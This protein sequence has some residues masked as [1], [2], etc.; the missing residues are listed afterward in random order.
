LLYNRVRDYV[1]IENIILNYGVTVY[2]IKIILDENPHRG[3]GVGK[4]YRWYSVDIIKL[5]MIV[6]ITNNVINRYKIDLSAY[7]IQ[8][9]MSFVSFSNI[10][11]AMI[12]NKC[13]VSF[14]EYR[15]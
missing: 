5:M 2:L 10:I 6:T 8:V 9:G 11:F 15:I 1:E 12:S 13:V 3:L 7:L 14:R 4:L